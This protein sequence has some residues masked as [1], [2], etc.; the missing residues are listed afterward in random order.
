MARCH[1]LYSA[2]LVMEEKID[3]NDLVNSINGGSDF[4]TDKNGDKLS[5]ENKE[6]ECMDGNFLCTFINPYLFVLHISTLGYEQ[7]QKV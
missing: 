1:T 6:T 2:E 3:Y 4:C 7:I 5:T